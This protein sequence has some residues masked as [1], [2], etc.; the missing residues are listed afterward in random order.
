[1]TD[2]ITI[3][4]AV[5]RRV[6]HENGRLLADAGETVDRTAYWVRRLDDEDVVFADDAVA[7]KPRTR[8]AQGD[9]A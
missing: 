2:R 9:Q 4:P 7:D 1:M 3:K 8:R 6:R 5:G